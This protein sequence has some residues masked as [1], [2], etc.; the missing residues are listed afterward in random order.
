MSVLVWLTN[1]WIREAFL[2]NNMDG[3]GIFPYIIS[4]Q[5]PIAFNLIRLNS[6]AFNCQLSWHKQNFRCFTPPSNEQLKFFSSYTPSRGFFEMHKISNA[7]RL[8]LPVMPFTGLAHIKRRKMKLRRKETRSIDRSSSKT[9]EMQIVRKYL[10]TPDV[11]TY[12]YV[13]SPPFQKQYCHLLNLW[14]RGR[15]WSL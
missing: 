1:S 13:S 6:E 10:Y 15:K 9:D 2:G 8:W 14:T 3:S 11:H 7:G 12:G 4:S 5:V